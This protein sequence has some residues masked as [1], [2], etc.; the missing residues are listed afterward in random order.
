[1]RMRATLKLRVKVKVAEVATPYLYSGILG[2]TDAP[3][4]NE[5]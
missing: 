2:L 5:K 4:E 3:K 1:M